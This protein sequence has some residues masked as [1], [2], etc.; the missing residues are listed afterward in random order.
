MSSET[1]DYLPWWYRNRRQRQQLGSAPHQPSRDFILNP[2]RPQRS[3]SFSDQS[4]R[5][6]PDKRATGARKG[7]AAALSDTS[8]PQQRPPAGHHRDPRPEATPG[9]SAGCCGSGQEGAV[10]ARRERWRHSGRSCRRE[11]EK[12]GWEGR[13]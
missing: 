1:N 4:K 9:R 10:L 7:A 2:S 5:H 8:A 3:S 13:R 12:E 11:E 6:H